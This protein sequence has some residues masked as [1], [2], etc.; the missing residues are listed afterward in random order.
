MAC[1]P[2]SNN[3]RPP[4]ELALQIGSE[5][6]TRLSSPNMERTAEIARHLASRDEE[7]VSYIVAPDARIAA[8]KALRDRIPR[9][10]HGRWSERDPETS[11]AALQQGYQGSC[12]NSHREP[13]T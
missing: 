1:A 6:S 9:D 7:R 11:A 4:P 10:Q 3:I 12:S 8:G 13:P 5:P 2:G